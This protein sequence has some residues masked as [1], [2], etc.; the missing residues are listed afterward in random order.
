MDRFDIRMQLCYVVHI[1]YVHQRVILVNCKFV[2]WA[3]QVFNNVPIF[4]SVCVHCDIENGANANHAIPVSAF[5]QKNIIIE[6]GQM[7][8]FCSL[9]ENHCSTNRSSEVTIKRCLKYLGNF[10]L[11]FNMIRSNS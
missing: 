6:I 10:H 3:L 4:V 11:L 1:S 9:R 5:V 7:L 2:I 8:L